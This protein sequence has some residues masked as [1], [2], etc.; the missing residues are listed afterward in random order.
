M[1]QMAVEDREI[2][3]D[4]LAQEGQHLRIG[5]R[6]ECTEITIGRHV[7]RQL[8]IVP[9][10]PSQYLKLLRALAAKSTIPIGKLQEDRGGLS[11]A[12]AALSASGFGA[13]LRS[14]PPPSPPS[15]GVK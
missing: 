6:G 13:A 4:P 2:V 3:V 12:R 8:L 9:E 10:Q 5:L 15:R 7:S 1:L 11:K 14:L